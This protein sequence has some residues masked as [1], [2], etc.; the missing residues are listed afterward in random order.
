VQDRTVLAVTPRIGIIDGVGLNI[1]IT[2]D[3]ESVEVNGAGLNCTR[4]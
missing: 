3:P 2:I 1:V 4:H